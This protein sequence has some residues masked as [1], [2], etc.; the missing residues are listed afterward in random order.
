MKSL[1]SDAQISNESIINKNSIFS[2]QCLEEE[3]NSN[4]HSA[5][6]SNSNSNSNSSNS[7]SNSNSFKSDNKAA[8]SKIDSLES[9][10]RK[11][12]LIVDAN[13]D[14]EEKK[15]LRVKNNSLE[16][17]KKPEMIRKSKS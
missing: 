3:S 13:N 6:A 10:L 12:E 1:N 9:R 5:S 15:K 11:L 7:N 16:E 14:I 8:N 2:D 4:S 17:S